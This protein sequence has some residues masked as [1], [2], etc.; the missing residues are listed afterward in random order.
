MSAFPPPNPYGIIYDSAF[1]EIPALTLSEAN[2]KY[3]KKTTPD[4]ASAL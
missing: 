2:A 1:F 4:I 3:L